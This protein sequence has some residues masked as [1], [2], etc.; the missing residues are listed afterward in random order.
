M[1]KIDY[2]GLESTL[3]SPDSNEETSE[4]EPEI[5]EDS[6]GNIQ[7]NIYAPSPEESEIYLSEEDK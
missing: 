1:N 7:I 6:D 5:L 3:L 2:Y 4:G